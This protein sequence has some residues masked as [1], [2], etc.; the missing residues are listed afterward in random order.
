MRLCENRI[1]I[2]NVWT[3]RVVSPNVIPPFREL[4]LR[5]RKRA[6]SEQIGASL[7]T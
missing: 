7:R 6:K 5:F 4:S 2:K 3:E 1:D